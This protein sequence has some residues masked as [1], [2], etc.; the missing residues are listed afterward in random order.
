MISNIHDIY[1]SVCLLSVS[2]CQSVPLEFLRSFLYAPVWRGSAAPCARPSTKK[3]TKRWFGERH[4][5]EKEYGHHKPTNRGLTTK[6]Y[7]HA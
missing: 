3:S 7:L 5:K 2:F 1:D 6:E 4:K